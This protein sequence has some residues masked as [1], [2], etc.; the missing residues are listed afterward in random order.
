M[1]RMGKRELVKKEQGNERGVGG[2]GR[3]EK[4]GER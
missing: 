3:R 1:G 2:G 4:Q